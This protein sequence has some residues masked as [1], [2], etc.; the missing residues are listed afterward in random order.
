MACLL[1]TGFDTGAQTPLF[2]LY[3]SQEEEE[4][5]CIEP[6]SAAV[7]SGK[8][9]IA[10]TILSEICDDAIKEAFAIFTEVTKEMELFEKDQTSEEQDDE[11]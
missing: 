8:S 9:T 3:Y 5:L 2:A 4:D 6:R 10:A 1:A 11:S 7:G